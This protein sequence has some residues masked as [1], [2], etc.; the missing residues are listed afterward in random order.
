MKKIELKSRK[1]LRT[2]FGCLSFTAVAF[3]FQ[4]CYGSQPAFY[5]IRMTGVVKAKDT[6]AP[7]KGIQ[8]FVK[9]GD[10]VD[11]YNYAFTDKK[12]KFDFYA[13]VPNYGWWDE[14]SSYYYPPDSVIVQFLD[15]DGIENGSF[16]DK[17]I[18]IDPGHKDEVKMN[19]LLENKQ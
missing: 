10:Y 4:A 17:T 5:D 2:L 11:N 15:I 12:G 6:N 16:A 14:A 8:V 3:V 18:F 7:I 1:L 19:V 9:C 13:S